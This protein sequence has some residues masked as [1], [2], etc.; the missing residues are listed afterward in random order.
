MLLTVDEMVKLV[1]SSVNVQIPTEDEKNP[2]LYD[3]AYLEM[4]DDDIKLFM[5]LGVTRA[6][7]DVEDLSELPDGSEFAIV[8]LTKIEL[9]LKL[10]VLEAPKVDMG[11]DNNNYLKRDQR[12]SHYMKLAEDAK[13]QYDDWLENEATGGINT[14]N[15]YDVLLS[16]RHFTRRNYE[17]QVTPKVHVYIDEV[18]TDSVNFRWKMTNSSHFGRYKVFISTS[19]I[20]DK[21]DRCKI[22][23][24]ATC[25]K[26]TSNIRDTYHSISGLVPDTQ[27]FI[28]V[29]SL[30]RNQVFGY[31][32]ISFTTLKE[33]EDEED[34]SLSEL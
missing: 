15:S 3:Q 28:L 30:E 5:K 13:E 6:Y 14:V 23:E 16:N 26:I 31:S 34:L 21:Y 19:P 11:A 10:A 9:Y 18:T 12:F 33:I 22:S 1:R 25:I 24:D 8:L 4:T 27:Y 32:E 17:K 20:M 29:I 7:P 2:L